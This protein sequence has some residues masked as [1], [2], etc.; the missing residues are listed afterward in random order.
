MESYDGNKT[1]TNTGSGREHKSEYSG[2]NNYFGPIG[3]ISI[4]YHF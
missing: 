2:N 1:E 4:N 3:Q